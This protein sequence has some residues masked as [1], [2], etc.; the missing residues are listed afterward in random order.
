MAIHLDIS[1][2]RFGRLIAIKYI[3]KD[4]KRNAIWLF[5]CDCGKEHISLAYNAK[6]GKASS[7]G[8]YAKEKAAS[9]SAR[10]TKMAILAITKHGKSGTR[11]YETYQNMISRCFRK[12]NSNYHDYGG[13]GI[14]VC[15]EW[16]NDMQSFFDWAMNNGYDDNL[17]IDR[18]DNNKGYS[19]ENCRWATCTEQSRNTRS[20]VILTL[21]GKSKILADW[22]NETCIPRSTIKG[23]IMRGLSVAEAL[24][25]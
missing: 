10:A 15:E 11:L 1:G 23:R 2:Q 3:G 13:R 19:P 5:R 9:Q 25:L 22:A 20:N 4:K 17:T 8:C 12:E 7:C 18:K 16:I 24:Q 14:S 6:S 21:N